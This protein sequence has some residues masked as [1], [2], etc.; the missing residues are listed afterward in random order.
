MPALVAKSYEGLEQLTEPY[1][2]NGKMY[3][4]VRTKSGQPKQVRAYSE[5]EYAKFYPEVKIIQPARSQREILGFGE[6]GYIWVFKGDTYEN[7]GWFKHAP[8]RFARDLG[9]YLPSNIEM[10][11]PLPA[12]ITPIK[13]MWDSVV[14]AENPVRLRP[15]NEVKAIVDSLI[16]DPGTSEYVGNIGDRLDLVLTCTKAITLDSAYGISY[17][18]IFNDDDG[19]IFVWTTATKQLNEN[20]EYAVRGTVKD[21]RTYRN[22]AQTILTRCKVEEI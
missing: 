4:K 22:Q 21:H 2:L 5:K 10:P 6:A 11:D 19:N 9:W 14:S 1:S 13:L 8:T 17:M 7:L 15:E 16:Y 3:V 12:G 18:N 20:T